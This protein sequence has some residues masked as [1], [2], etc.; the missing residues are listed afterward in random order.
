[1]KEINSGYSFDRILG[2][3][4]VGLFGLTIIASGWLYTSSATATTTSATATVRINSACSLSSNVDTPH[5]TTLSNGSYSGASGYGQTTIKAF[6]NDTGGYAIYAIGYTSGE[7]ANTTMHWNKASSSSDNTNAIPTEVYSA[8]NMSNSS[9]SMKLA[10][11]GGTYAATIVDGT[12]HEEDFTSWHTIPANYTKVAYRTASTDTYVDTNS[13]GSSV[14]L[15]YDT[16]IIATQPAGSYTG[17]VKFTLVHPNDTPYIP[18]HQLEPL[19]TALC[20]ANSICY[21]PNYSDIIGS[22]SSLPQTTT[23]LT[24]ASPQAGAVSATANSTTELI[25]PNYKRIGYGF[26]GWSTN[27]DATTADNPTIYGPNE[28]ISTNPTNGGLDVSGGAVLYPVWIESAGNLQSW[29]GCSSLTPASYNT[30]T[31]VLTA[32]LSSI[33]ALTDTRDNN[34]YTVARLADGQCWMTENL[35]LNSEHTT[36]AEDI[37][38]AQGYG[39]STTYGNFIGLADSEDAYF[40]SNTTANTLYSTNGSNSTIN[41][42]TNND[43]AY[44]LP[45]YNNNNTNMATNATNSDGT[46][47]LEDKYNTYGTATKDNHLRW[48]G[49]GNYY[50]WPAAM[51]STKYYSTYSGTTGS[52]AAGTSLCP[53]G[54]HL[55]LGYQSTGTLT[56]TVANDALDSA[57]RVGSFSYLDRRMGGTGQSNSTNSIT[58]ATMSTY[59]RKFPNNFVYSGY[60]LDARATNR[61]TY[62][63]CWSSSASSSG[64]TYYLY[65]GSSSVNPGGTNFSGKY[66]GYSVR[67][68]AGS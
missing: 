2:L 37:A 41:I 58:S 66:A 17:K 33:T 46:T 48:Y 31:G 30:E 7:Y 44:R 15:T 54:W 12:N 40:T 63:G 14:T 8:G 20:P 59:W 60:W 43:P 21:A 67:C 45:R 53:L 38:K 1:M 42:G 25:A 29:T 5:T 22:M 34:V 19:D 47:T 57:N 49:Y 35:R 16:Y 68:M 27:L 24:N 26:A 50:N 52:D 61:S 62:G 51:A 56:G 28:T 10:S 55:P 18:Y 64:S 65:F 3:F 23:D 11:S 4:S 32:T 39:S 6:C 9:W 13:I 36:S